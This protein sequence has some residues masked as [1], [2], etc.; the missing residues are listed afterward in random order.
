M[1]SINTKK[2]NWAEYDCF[3]SAKQHN[4]YDANTA[5][6]GMLPCRLSP[7]HSLKDI[8]SITAI[9]NVCSTP[10][11]NLDARSLYY[12]ASHRSHH[13]CLEAPS[14]VHLACNCAECNYQLAEAMLLKWSTREKKNDLAWPILEVKTSTNLATLTMIGM[15]FM[16]YLNILY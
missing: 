10:R 6:D 5:G 4:T 3:R 1:R 7:R 14:S 13:C 16:P 9:N 8:Y 12:T 2:N 15:I 11:Y